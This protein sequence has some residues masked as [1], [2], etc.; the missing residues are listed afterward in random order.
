MNLKCSSSFLCSLE[1]L[2]IGRVLCHQGPSCCHQQHQFLPHCLPVKICYVL[3]LY[4]AGTEPGFYCLKQWVQE[5]WSCL[6]FNTFDF[7]TNLPFFNMQSSLKKWYTIFPKHLT[8]LRQ[9]SMWRAL[10][11]STLFFTII[12]SSLLF[13][14]FLHNLPVLFTE[15][16]YLLPNNQLSVKQHWLEN[17]PSG[18]NQNPLLMD[19]A[20]CWQYFLP[21]P[22]SWIVKNKRISFQLPSAFSQDTRCS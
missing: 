3:N 18:K 7:F 15:I 16:V 12:F 1:V 11:C 5:K 2:K 20:V 19:W 17:C 8:V 10:L 6:H 9:K 4:R 13:C 22:Q 21:F 14:M